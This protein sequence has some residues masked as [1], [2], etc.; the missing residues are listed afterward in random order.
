MPVQATLRWSD[1][2]LSY[3]VSATLSWDVNADNEAQALSAVNV[4][5]GSTHPKDSN[6]IA[7]APV[8]RT[9]GGPKVFIVTVSYAK[10]GD[11]QAQDPDKPSVQWSRNVTREQV[12]RDAEGNPILNS[13]GDPFDPPPERDF[14]ER[15]FSIFRQESVYDLDLAERFEDTVNDGTVTFL[16]KYTFRDGQLK[17]DSY[18]PVS[19]F[20]FDA[21]RVEM[22][23]RFSFRRDGWD[24]RI[25]DQG[26]NGFYSKDGDITKAPIYA[27]DGTQISSDTLLDGGGSP[28]DDTLRVGKTGG[29]PVSATNPPVGATVERGDA[30]AF[31]KYKRYPRR[32]FRGLQL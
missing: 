11:S 22:E 7:S 24:Y 23:Y 26:R 19:R 21:V 10:A 1:V 8:V 32:D 6:L 4:S 14:G 15:S 3:G 2:S 5:V 25:I 9:N 27:G 31:L 16:G 20:P 12:D 13:A 28:L 29:N 18:L 17:L 30:A